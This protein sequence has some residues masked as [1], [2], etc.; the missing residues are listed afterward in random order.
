MAHRENLIFSE[1]YYN[2]TKHHSDTTTARENGGA[3]ALI[4]NF[5]FSLDY[6]FLVVKSQAERAGGGRIRKNG[7]NIFFP[8]FLFSFSTSSQFTVNEGLRL[9]CKNGEW[10]QEWHLHCK[11][12]TIKFVKWLR[13][14]FIPTQEQSAEQCRGKLRD[15]VLLTIEFNLEKVREEK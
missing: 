8:F 4:F 1:R 10:I 3:K 7:E 14:A 9:L 6:P 15:F 12:F 11:F 13:S 2:E 5:R